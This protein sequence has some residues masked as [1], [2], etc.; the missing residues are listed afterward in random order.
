MD[1]WLT[2]QLKERLFA[3][4]LQTSA[5]IGRKLDNRIEM[6]QTIDERALTEQFVDSFDTRSTENLWGSTIDQLRDLGIY[7]RTQ[8]RKST[9]EHRTGADIGLVIDRTVHAPA[10]ASNAR[11]A[12]LIQ[13]KKI[14]EDGMVQDFF[15]QVPSSSARQS[16]LLLDLTPSAF[17]FVF[18]PPSLVRT[19][20]SL[21][22]IGFVRGAKGCSSPVWN[23]G[24]FEFGQSLPAILSAQQIAESVGILVV[25]A[26]AVEAQRNRGRGARLED[27]ISNCLPFWYW[28]GELLIPGFVGDRR[29]EILRV[30]E[31]VASAD[32]QN[33]RALEVKYSVNVGYGNG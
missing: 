26:L 18:T 22:P 33:D 23:C 14:D 21:E 3:P 29:P 4:C 30:A 25:P 6:G 11:Y 28:F 9:V 2:D 15:H 8:V 12:A 24:A 16:T 13:C 31:N 32:L 7:L 17:Y 5:K 27:I 20:A 19:Y 1:P 10:G